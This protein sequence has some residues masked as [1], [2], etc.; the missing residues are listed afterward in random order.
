MCPEA[1]R[2]FSLQRK[3]VALVLDCSWV[4]PVGENWRERLR[5][6]EL[7]IGG[8]RSIA[9]EEMSVLF[10]SGRAVTVVP[11]YGL[12]VAQAQPAPRLCRRGQ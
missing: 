3:R 5:C 7:R 1:N 11:G 8:V 9:P 10:D 6:R 2:T 12:A 4:E